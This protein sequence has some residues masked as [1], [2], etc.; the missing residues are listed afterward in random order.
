MSPTRANRRRKGLSLMEVLVVTGI[1]S[2]VGAFTAVMYKTAFGDYE[3]SSM[4]RSMV[5]YARNVTNKVA[6]MVATAV[7]RSFSEKAFQAPVKADPNESIYCNFLSTANYIKTSAT[8]TSYAFDD[9]EDVPS[10]QPLFRYSIMW[11]GTNG[12]ARKG[13]NTVYLQRHTISPL[14]SVGPPLDELGPI[15]PGTPAQTLGTNIGYIGYRLT[16]ASTMQLRVVVYAV[17]PAGRALDGRL[18][19]TMTRRNRQTAGGDKRYELLTSIP[20]PTVQ[21]R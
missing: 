15:T 9:G 18:M 17:D 10:Y 1:M 21:I 14:P 16:F 4:Q 3:S 20:I 8:E 13:P 12:D 6:A 2:L 11:S 7:P 5:G 19:R